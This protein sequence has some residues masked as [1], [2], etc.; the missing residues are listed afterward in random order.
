MERLDGGKN[1]WKNGTKKDLDEQDNHDGVVSHPEPDILEYEVKWA[2][3]A[4]LLIK[5]VD[6]LE[7]Q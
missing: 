4:L 2:L 5:L 6:V 3:R 7:F 1:T